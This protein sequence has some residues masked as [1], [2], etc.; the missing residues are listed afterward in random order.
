MESSD[1]LYAPAAIAPEKEPPVP[2]KKDP[3][4]SL[5]AVARRRNL[6]PCQDYNRG[7]PARRLVSDWA[8]VAQSF[9]K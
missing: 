3:T 1:Q 2:I 7:R 9:R 6:N 4:A 8:K 5:D